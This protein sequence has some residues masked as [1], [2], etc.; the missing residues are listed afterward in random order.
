MQQLKNLL[1][2]RA[3]AFFSMPI[4]NF[5]SRTLFVKCTNFDLGK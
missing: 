3:V 5:N 1:F 2:V 4:S